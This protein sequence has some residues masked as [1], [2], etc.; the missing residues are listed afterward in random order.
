MEHSCQATERM[1]QSWR[2]P[3]QSALPS[4]ASGAS[5]DW[6]R[7]SPR[8]ALTRRADMQDGF[9]AQ[10][11][12]TLAVYCLCKELGFEYVHTPMVDISNQGLV[13][14]EQNCHTSEYVE[15]CNA[16]ACLPHSA[17]IR[18]LSSTERDQW[19]LIEQ[20]LT[21]DELLRLKQ[22]TRSSNVLVRFPCLRPPFAADLQPS[23][24]AHA[25]GLLAEGLCAIAHQARMCGLP[26]T[27]T[28][29][30]HV[31]RGDYAIGFSHRLLPPSY[32]LA[33]CERVAAI[34]ERH[35]LP[36]VC[37]LYTEA[38]DK[39]TVITPQHPGMRGRLR[40]SVQL[41]ADA[42]E[43]AEYRRLPNLQCHVN[44]A[45]LVTFTRMVRADVLIASRS[46]FSMCAHYVKR[47]GLTIFP[48][49]WQGYRDDDGVAFDAPDVDARVEA[50]VLK[51]ASHGS[52]DRSSDL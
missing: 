42:H 48:S 37:E 12:R 18:T 41:P 26:G 47:D 22:A 5:S 36:F 24:Y 3:R 23:M 20:D 43:L 33:L 4:S 7:L 16:L 8:I 32:Y 45:P 34:C 31:R 10:L 6:P 13:A 49:E 38:L 9:G 11:H 46:G 40:A 21:A 19:S 51:A 44:E 1:R 2:A 30:V 27:I 52:R 39:A 29:G 35:G 28:I 14:L 25:R 17:D 15:R 50:A